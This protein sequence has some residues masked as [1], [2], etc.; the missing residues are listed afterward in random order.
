LD[1]LWDA[2]SPCLALTTWL[3][4]PWGDHAAD[5]VSA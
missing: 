2:I 1:V 4:I 3:Q 5:L